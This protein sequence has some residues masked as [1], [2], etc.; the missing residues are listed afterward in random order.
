MIEDVE[1]GDLY[2]DTDSLVELLTA[3]WLAD[4]KIAGRLN[5]AGGA[6]GIYSLPSTM[7]KPMPCIM[8]TVRSLNGDSRISGPGVYRPDLDVAVRHR[9]PTVASAILIR[10]AEKFR[11]P[12][13]VR[14]PLANADWIINGF[15]ILDPNVPV[16]SIETT[17]GS[18]FEATG[19]ASL[20]AL[21]K[22]EPE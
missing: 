2:G 9:I 5:R 10:I 18:Y 11:M 20:R 7:K 17:E 12:E 22:P 16:Q 8:V 15:R 19:E 3:P 4:P 21:R 14:E 6:R 1:N 13:I